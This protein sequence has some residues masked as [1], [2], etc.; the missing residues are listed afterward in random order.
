M[1]DMV[2]AVRGDAKNIEI[3]GK[4]LRQL[5]CKFCGV[6]SKL[7]SIIFVQTTRGLFENQL[8]QLLLTWRR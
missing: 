1:I 6:K 4:T 5:S 2:V 8:R 3:A 7:G